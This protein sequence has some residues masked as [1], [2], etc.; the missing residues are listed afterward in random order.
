MSL[1]SCLIK[2][3]CKSCR[4]AFA[5]SCVPT[6]DNLQAV[7]PQ[8]ASQS[9]SQSHFTTDGPSVSL[10][11]CRAPSDFS[12]C[13]DSCG[14]VFVSR[15][16]W[17]DDGSV[18]CKWTFNYIGYFVCHCLKSVSQT[19]QVYIYI[20]GIFY[21]TYKDLCQSRLCTTNYAIFWVTRATTA[22]KS[23]ERS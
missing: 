10:P 16:L 9:Q 14:F 6:D 1:H 20:R 19:L 11:W 18:P 15:P 7:H 2:M 13:V 5:Q 4:V 8:S 3:V 21:N 22:V 23:F 17:R 12:L